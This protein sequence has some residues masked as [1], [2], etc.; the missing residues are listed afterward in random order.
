MNVPTGSEYDPSAPWNQRP[1]KMRVCWNCEGTR[2]EVNKVPVKGL[3]NTYK[4]EETECSACLGSGE[5]PE[6][7]P[8][9]DE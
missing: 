2:V 7:D 1:E 6:D 9:Y 3:I 8:F 5:L 4:D